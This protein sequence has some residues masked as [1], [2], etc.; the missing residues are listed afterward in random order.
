VVVYRNA[1]IRKYQIFAYSEWPGGL[2][3]SPSMSGTRPGQIALKISTCSVIYF[4]RTIVIGGNIASSW[5]V[6]Q[7]MGEDGYMDIARRL[8]LV[9]ERM[10]DGINAIEVIKY[11]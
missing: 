2:F 6:L 1:N 3:G 8:M 5:A 11:S 7:C 4:I 10:K 9:A